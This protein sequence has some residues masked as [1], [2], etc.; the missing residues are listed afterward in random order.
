MS[1]ECSKFDHLSLELDENYVLIT[2]DFRT[3]IIRL[4]VYSN[5]GVLLEEFTGNDAQDI[6]HILFKHKYITKMTHAAYIGKE[7]KK[8]EISL[9]IG[10][11][12]YQE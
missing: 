11:S 8:A 9:A 4:Q 7:L 6:Y 12:Y 2:P 10:G 5:E 3:R 1:I